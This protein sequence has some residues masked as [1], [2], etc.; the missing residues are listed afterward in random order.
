MPKEK[1]EIKFNHYMEAKISY[2]DDFD[3]KLL[4]DSKFRQGEKVLF[5]SMFEHIRSGEV[6]QL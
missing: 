2:L 5:S 1:E 4:E 6:H 3:T